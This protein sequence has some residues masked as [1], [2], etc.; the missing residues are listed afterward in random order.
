MA[1]LKKSRRTGKLVKQR[2]GGHLIR[3]CGCDGGISHPTSN[4]CCHMGN[5]CFCQ[6]ATVTISIAFECTGRDEGATVLEVGQTYHWTVV[7]SYQACYRT[8][9]NIPYLVRWA[10]YNPDPYTFH[11]DL[12]QYAAFDGDLG[13]GNS[14]GSNLT[15]DHGGN[16]LQAYM[17]S[18]MTST[19]DNCC[20]ASGIWAAADLGQLYHPVV[21]K[22]YYGNVSWTLAVSNNHCC[23]LGMPDGWYWFLSYDA[24]EVVYFDGRCWEAQNAVAAPAGEMENPTPD[25]SPDWAEVDCPYIMWGEGVEYAAGTVVNDGGNPPTLY[26]CLQDHTAS[27]ENAP[28]NGDYWVEVACLV[29]DTDQCPGDNQCA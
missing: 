18:R 12:Y 8:I 24:G 16:Y 2:G 6:H 23:H 19:K 22:H 1:H 17:N 5:C 9:D 15:L 27:W 3:G 21:N 13:G 20:S 11:D 14:W 26:L 29:K 28:P 25:T 7:M 4:P 10:G